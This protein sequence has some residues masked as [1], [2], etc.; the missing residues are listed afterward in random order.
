MYRQLIEPIAGT[1]IL[2]AAYLITR[3]YG[4]Q[5]SDPAEVASA[6]ASL[7]WVVSHIFGLLA[8][9]Q[10]G[11]LAQRL[12]DLAPSAGEG[13]SSMPRRA[14]TVAMVGAILVLPYYGA[15][16]F[17]LHAI[18]QQY[19]AE[20]DPATLAMADV[21]RN[22]PAA[23]TM[24]GAGLLL[25]AVSGVMVALAWAKVSG[26]SR[27]AWPLGIAM[28]LLLPQF[29]LPAAGR[30]AFGIAYLICAV[31]FVVAVLRRPAGHALGLPHGQQGEGRA[32]AGRAVQFS[33]AAADL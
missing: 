17:G 14:R 29:Y 26:G 1:G 31:V 6:F 22:Q 28:A 12:N 5:S 24:F 21:V 4:D 9:A 18:G 23:L 33:G 16:T 32:A 2:M 30:I 27:A 19:L 10:F 7:W 8:I 20:P 13:R 15:E 3:P 25:L 11:R